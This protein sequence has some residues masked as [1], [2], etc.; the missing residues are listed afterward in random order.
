[1][2]HS[3][4]FIAYLIAT[5]AL[6]GALVM[7]VEV[8][9]S[10]V[11]GPFFGVSLFVWTSLITVTMVALAAG[12]AIG[13]HLSD[14]R[15]SPDW[16]YGIIMVSGILVILIPALK[17]PILQMSLPLGLRWGSLTCAF[18][19]FGPALFLLGC[20][21]PYVVKIAAREMHNIGRT[22]GSFYAISTVGSV[23]GTLLTGFVLIAYLGVNQI[24]LLTGSLLIAL[25]V[26]YFLFFRR[27]WAAVFAAILPF[28]LLPQE[29]HV[30][31]VMPDGTRVERIADRDSFYGNLKVV[32]YSYQA[33]RNRELLIDGLVQGGMDQ[34]NGLSTYEYTYLLQFLPYAFN[35]DGKSC[36]MIGLGAGL[37]PTWFKAQGVDTEVVDIDPDVAELARKYFGFSSAIPVHIEDARYFL[38]NTAQRYDYLILDVF[39][40]ETTPGH[41]LSVEAMRLAKQRLAPD[42]VLAVNLIGSVNHHTLMTSSAVK[43]LQS[44]FDQ[45][46]IYPVF[47]ASAGEGTGNIEIIAYDGAQRAPQFDRIGNMAIHPGL[48]SSVHRSMQQPFSMQLHADAMIL[49]DNYNPVDFYDLWLKELLRKII[50]DTTDFDILLSRRDDPVLTA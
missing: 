33:K 18:L 2:Q 49:S 45:V 30:A 50:L 25:S 7:V 32:D 29:T 22:V 6:C 21:S 43:T 34:G 9:G 37:V 12:Y 35:P 3:K 41:L 13:G 8:L 48:E 36:L 17:G 10:R 4:G 11:I 26:F 42:G 27:K 40:G 46:A 23:F 5:A 31:K 15:S 24:F 44:V 38:I 14:R 1:M 39:S 20:V 47:D 16:L 28:L 19:L